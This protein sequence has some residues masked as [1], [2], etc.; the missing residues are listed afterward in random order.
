MNT[1]KIRSGLVCALLPVLRPGASRLPARRI[2]RRR[3]RREARSA[4][5]TSP[6]RECIASSSTRTTAAR[7]TAP[8]VAA[9]RRPPPAA[10]PRPP[11]APRRRS[12][13]H[14][15]RSG[16]C[17]PACSNRGRQRVATIA[18]MA[19]STTVAAMTTRGSPRG[20]QQ[21]Q[22]HYGNARQGWLLRGRP[23][24]ALRA[25]TALV[26]NGNGTRTGTAQWT[27]AQARAGRRTT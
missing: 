23:Q 19:E 21:W 5:S 3:A 26:N 16:R 20:R 15:G 12:R 25:A 24:S 27:L 13:R 2:R 4:R 8:R 7:R 10:V 9:P 14:D 22:R 6:A 1:K 17:E 18:A 11:Q